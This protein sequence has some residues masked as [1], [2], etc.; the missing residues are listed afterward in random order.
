MPMKKLLIIFVIFLSL[1]GASYAH[2]VLVQ[3]LSDFSKDDSNKDFSA[4]VIED[5]EFDSGLKF[6]A[7]S[8][9]N[10]KILKVV[11]AK[12]GKRDAYIVITPVSNTKVDGN[13]SLIE[14]S[15]LEAKV[16]G[17]SKKDWKQM[18]LDAGLA[19]GGQ[20]VKGLGQMFYF[21][22]GLI[23]PDEG[24]NRVQ[25]AFHN[26]YESTPFVYAEKGKDVDINQ[27][28]LLVLKFY[29][30]DVPKWRPIKRQK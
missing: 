12:R 10:G 18:G 8:T 30:T 4:K 15:N 3:S 9:I 14:D 29:H 11:D 20:F 1:T 13:I 25:T 28:D 21:S 2:N 7:N 19:V 24:R 6:E 17:Y 26:V 16:V 27:G 22:K 23:K 5:V